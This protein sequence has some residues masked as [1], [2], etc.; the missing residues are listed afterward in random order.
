LLSGF[1]LVKVS[2][3]ESGNLAINA[4]NGYEIEGRAIQVGGG[5]PKNETCNLR[6]WMMVNNMPSDCWYQVRFDRQQ[7]EEAGYAQCK[8]NAILFP[9]VIFLAWCHMLLFPCL[10][11]DIAILAAG[12]SER[13]AV[14]NLA[15]ATDNEEL[16]NFLS[17]AGTVTSVEVQR[18]SD[19]GR[20]KGWA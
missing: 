8:H 3:V 10:C 12:Y 4:L 11:L 18:H 15:W 14:G 20:S 16:R 5:T 2:S 9:H 19:T 7:T 17:Q 1:A 13:L 6:C